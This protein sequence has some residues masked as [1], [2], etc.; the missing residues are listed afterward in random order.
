MTAPDFVISWDVSEM[1]IESDWEFF[2]R[3][4]SLLGGRIHPLS[5]PKEAY[6]RASCAYEVKQCM[7]HPCGPTFHIRLIIAQGFRCQ[8]PTS[9][10]K[11]NKRGS[12]QNTAAVIQPTDPCLCPRDP[13]PP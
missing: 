11:F 4:I 5:E 8:A 7:S 6:F 9:A 1:A 2:T 3:A 12:R 13:R 10:C